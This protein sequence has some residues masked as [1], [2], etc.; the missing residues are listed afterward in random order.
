M[1]TWVLNNIDV[2]RFLAVVLVPWEL[3]LLRKGNIRNFTTLSCY[4]IWRDGLWVLIWV[5]LAGKCTV[6]VNKSLFEIDFMILVRLVDVENEIFSSP[7]LFDFGSITTMIVSST[8]SEFSL[9]WPQRCTKEDKVT[10][11]LL[12]GGFQRFISLRVCLE[13]QFVIEISVIIRVII[14]SLLIT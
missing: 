11:W 5:L 13:S 14:I 9:C 10:P 6:E 1:Y 8:S 12:F 4:M 2:F 3:N 7:A